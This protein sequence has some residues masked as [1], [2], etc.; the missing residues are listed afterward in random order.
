MRKLLLVIGIIFFVAM[1]ATY[2]GNNAT[3]RSNFFVIQNKDVHSAFKMDKARIKQKIHMKKFQEFERK[4]QK[5]QFVQYLNQL[6]ET[7]LLE[8]LEEYAQYCTETGESFE[9][10]AFIDPILKAWSNKVPYKDIALLLGD[11]ELDPNL[12]WFVLDTTR[13]ILDN[14]RYPNDELLVDAVSTIAADQKEDPNLRRKAIEWLMEPSHSSSEIRSL[15][16]KIYSNPKTPDNVKEF[17][18][19]V[20]NLSN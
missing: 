16:S 15:L 17:T 7:E 1:V 12:R 18:K 9:P 8:S 14:K 11:K 19:K 6:S 3:L 20:L 10:F 4:N 2:L 13:Y 5:E